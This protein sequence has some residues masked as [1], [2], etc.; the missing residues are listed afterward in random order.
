MNSNRN[1]GFGVDKSRL[2]GVGKRVD[3]FI[4][5]ED[6]AES[7][8]N[9]D[10][11]FDKMEE[12]KKL[13]DERSYMELVRRPLPGSII[14]VFKDRKMRNGKSME[15]W[16]KKS[17]L[18]KTGMM[19]FTSSISVPIYLTLRMVMPHQL[20]VEK[21]EEVT[22]LGEKHNKDDYELISAITE[23]NVQN[24]QDLKNVLVKIGTYHPELSDFFTSLMTKVVTK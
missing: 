23:M 3:D 22:G 17:F 13:T 10:V 4:S 20:A 12:Y 9:E 15:Q 6:A 19:L 18:K 8:P 21:A 14:S 24:R 11:D 7:M 2:D 5:E 16:F 1:L